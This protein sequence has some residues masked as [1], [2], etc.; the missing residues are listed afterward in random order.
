M[1]VLLQGS[2]YNIPNYRSHS[3][4]PTD[5]DKYGS[6]RRV[7]ENEVRDIQQRQMSHFLFETLKW[8]KSICYCSRL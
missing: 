8:L 5:V 7:D 6:L 4:L 2:L 1:F 3:E